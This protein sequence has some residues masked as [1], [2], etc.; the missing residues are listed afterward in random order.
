MAIGYFGDIIFETKDSKILTFNNLKQ[1]ASGNW[2]KHERQ[3]K[4]PRKEFLNPESQ[5]VSFDIQLKASHGVRPRKTIE[6]LIKYAES[7]II[8]PLVV[9]G[10]K[11]GSKWCTVKVSA[12]WETIYNKGELVSAKVN[13][14]LEE[15]A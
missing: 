6:T 14:S 5:K 2:G 7:G 4:K 13:L 12:A 1:D 9:G 15:Y 10:K 11:I 8:N 3:G